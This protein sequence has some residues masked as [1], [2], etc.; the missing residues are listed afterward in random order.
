MSRVWSKLARVG[1]L[2]ISQKETNH[3]HGKAKKDLFAT[4]CMGLDICMFSEEA[5]LPYN[6]PSFPSPGGHSSS[7]TASSKGSTGPRKGEGTRGQHQRSTTEQGESSY[8]GT[9][10]QY[11]GEL[12]KSEQVILVQL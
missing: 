3:G 2:S 12:C 5:I 4:K 7:G 6:K 9:N 1:H 8:M 10:A 11:S